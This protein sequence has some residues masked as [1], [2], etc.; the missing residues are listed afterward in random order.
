MIN[1][2]KDH[3]MNTRVTGQNIPGRSRCWITIKYATYVFTNTNNIIL[4]IIRTLLTILY[5][6]Y[7]HVIAGKFPDIYN[8]NIQYQIL[9]FDTH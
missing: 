5:E 7:L 2:M 1:T 8:P 9:A 3:G 4:E 6:I